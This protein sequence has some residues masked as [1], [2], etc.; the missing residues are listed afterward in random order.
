MVDVR[1]TVIALAL[2]LAG[3]AGAVY[4]DAEPGTFSGSV[5]VVW[6]GEGGSSGDGRFLFLPDPEAPLIFRRPNPRSN[7]AVIQPG[8]MYTD[9]GSIPRIAQA[10]NG[11]SPW[12]YA[13][14]YMIHDWLFAAR[15][16][17][18]DGRNEPQYDQLRNVT[19]EDSARIL[20]ESIR[21]LVDARKVRRNDA[22][23]A[24]ITGAVDS[25]VAREMWDRKGACEDVKVDSTTLAGARR[26]IEPPPEA[27]ARQFNFLRA[28]PARKTK[29]IAKEQGQ[30]RVVAHVTF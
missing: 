2:I 3:C 26:Q 16:C 4:E 10:F 20:A 23:G 11:L 17:L 6:V 27:A 12:G 22:A 5:Y 15:H 14:A 29:T 9:G 1:K 30:T 21:G 8:P 18:V 25:F 19:F 28:M 7:G 24:T 13:P